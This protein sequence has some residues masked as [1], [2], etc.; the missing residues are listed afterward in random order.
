MVE[1]LFDSYKGRDV[2]LT[3]TASDNEND[4]KTSISVT[5]AL[6]QSPI[7][8]NEEVMASWINDTKKWSDVF[9]VKPYEYLSI[10]SVREIPWFDRESGKWIPKTEADAKRDATREAVNVQSDAEISQAEA[11]VNAM[12]I[13]DNDG[14]EDL[15]F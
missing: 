6:S 13:D 5:Q 3:I 12:F 8:K 15:P 9:V 11:A 2:I 4:N 1:N 14:E 7:S 10:V